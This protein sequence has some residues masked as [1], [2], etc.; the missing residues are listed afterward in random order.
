MH[1]SPGRHHHHRVLRQSGEDA[2]IN[3]LREQGSGPETLELTRMR[4]ASQRATVRGSSASMLRMPAARGL[5][6]ALAASRSVATMPGDA[7]CTATP[8]PLASAARDAC[9]QPCGSYGCHCSTSN[10]TS[11]ATYT[12]YALYALRPIPYTTAVISA[13]WDTCIGYRVIS[14]L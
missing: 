7:R 8:D 10:V 14:A 1:R 12:P 5:H 4:G 11:T 3:P 6:A 2:A 9:T 13:S